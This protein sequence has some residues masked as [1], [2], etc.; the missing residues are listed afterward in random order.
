M[1]EMMITFDGEYSI[2]DVDD[3]LSAAVSHCHKAVT[4]VSTAR[5]ILHPGSPDRSR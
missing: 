4:T 2:K 1:R 5:Q 3:Q